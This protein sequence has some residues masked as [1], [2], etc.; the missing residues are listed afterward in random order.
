[1]L[2]DLRRL[3]RPMS[4]SGSQS[5]AVVCR[6]CSELF[7]ARQS[8]VACEFVGYVPTALCIARLGSDIFLLRLYQNLEVNLESMI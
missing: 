6:D 5:E 2:G 8:K 4:P 1:M 7:R 3:P